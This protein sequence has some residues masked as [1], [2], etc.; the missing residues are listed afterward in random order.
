VVVALRE[1]VRESTAEAGAGS[2]DQQVAWIG[3][4]AIGP[5]RQLRPRGDPVG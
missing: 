5:R 1:P 2:D 3:G 4:G